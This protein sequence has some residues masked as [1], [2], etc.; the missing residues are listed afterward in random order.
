EKQARI[1]AL[2]RKRQ[3]TA[4]ASATRYKDFEFVLNDARTCYTL[5]DFISND[6]NE[7]IADRLFISKNTVKDYVTKMLIKTGFRS[8]TELAVK[9]REL[10]LVVREE[11]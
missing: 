1:D 11:L 5:D 3:L 2:Q 10:G 6:T 9:A 8:R 7:E 4:T